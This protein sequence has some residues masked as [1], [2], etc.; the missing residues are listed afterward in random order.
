MERT[1][2]VL[3]QQWKFAYLHHAEARNLQPNCSK[4]LEGIVLFHPCT[5]PGAMEEQIGI[6]DLYVGT[7]VLKA[8]DYED[9]H[10]YYTTNFDYHAE[11]GLLQYLDFEGLDTFCEIYLNGKPLG[12]TCDMLIAHCFPLDDVAKEGLNE[13]FLHFLPTCIEVRKEELKPGNYCQNISN[14]EMLV[15]RKAGHMFGW[16]IAPRIVSGGIWK[17]VL[18]EKKPVEHIDDVY[19]MT[20]EETGEGQPAI[21]DVFFRLTIAEGLLKEYTVTFSGTCGDSSFHE[22]MPVRFTQGIQSITIPHARLWWPKGYGK[23]NLYEFSVT[24]SKKHQ[25]IDKRE[26]RFGIRTVQLY[27]TPV[28]DCDHKGKFEF[29]VNNQRIFVMGTNWV[30]LDALHVHDKERLGKVLALVDDIGCNAIRCWG[31]NVYESE[32][33]FDFCDEKGILV[34]QDFAMAC[35]VYPEDAHFMSVMQ[36]EVT[37][38]V[39]RLRNHPSLFLWSGDNECDAMMGISAGNRDPEA[40]AITRKLIPD[41]LYL[42]DPM[43]PYLPSSPYYSSLAHNVGINHISE[44]HLWGPRDYYKSDFYLQS[45]CHFASEIGYHGCPSVSSVKKFITPTHTWPWKDNPEWHVHATCDTLSDHPYAYRIP[46]MAN[47]IKEL[48]GSIPDNLEEFALASQISQA[49]A[50]KFFIEL[51][52]Q[53]NAWRS[54]IIW[55][56]IMDCWPQFSDA[57]VDYYFVKKLA[58]WYIKEAQNPLLVV[59]AEPKDWKQEVLVVNDTKESVS[60]SYR[61]QDAETETVIAEGKCSMEAHRSVDTGAI[62]YSQGDK[63]LYAITWK[64]A[65]GVEGKSHYLAGNPPFDLH[66]YKELASK[67]GLLDNYS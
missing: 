36:E 6:K 56:N 60:L 7:N 18:L 26:G 29:V 28:T 31:G 3:D 17:D 67:I 11:D 16:D 41:I 5:V 49:E 23:Q 21:V 61:I 54:G 19:V 43:R 51:F 57:V 9:C 65:D 39:R 38:V 4:D 12:K 52:R 62:P 14:Y 48:F 1:K 37:S 20:K 50:M 59:L 55:W 46:L 44:N 53:Q 64:T 25:V 27:S 8:Q 22:E 34:W 58:Y 10:L 33:F 63:R 13:L 40:N 15:C 2:V 45:L 32:E 35:G 47:Q 30:P 66:W 24:L 42:E